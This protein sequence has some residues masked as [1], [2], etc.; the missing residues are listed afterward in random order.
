MSD[1]PRCRLCGASDPW[2]FLALGDLPLANAFLTREELETPEPRYP[3]TLMHCPDC[4]LVQLEETVAPESLFRE[5]LYL[6]SVSRTMLR[7]ARDTSERLIEELALGEDTLVVELGSNDGYML[8]YF[9]RLGIPV[10]G[11]DPAENLNELAAAKGIDTMTRF[12][13]EQVARELRDRD[14]TASLVIANNVL[15]HVPDMND[16]VA[17]VRELMATG[18]V[19][20]IE[21]P[22]V[23]CMIDRRE[24]DT[25]Y[26]EHVSYFSLTALQRLFGGHG[27][28]IDDVELL[29]IHGGS[30]QLFVRPEEECE[31]SP[32]VSELLREEADWVGDPAHYRAFK[33][34]YDS[35]KETLNAFFS[36]LKARPANIAAYG[37]AAK[38]TMFTN[39]FGIDRRF[40]DFVVDRNTYKQGRFLPGTHVPIHDPERLLAERPDFCLLLVWNLA[41]EIV[42]QERDYLEGGGRFVIPVPRPRIL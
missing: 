11:I 40:L 21:V 39:L 38:G 3:L 25:I 28:A 30:L 5:Y 27:L 9:H 2:P 19:A 6:S 34:G 15:A 42:Q 1:E 37:A 33:D 14:R 16:F 22:W 36:R 23:K 32:R 20:V 4:T 29:E 7:H 41:D 18:G 8:Q 13:G 26:H 12:F 17:G 10:L 35:L 24:Y 31:P